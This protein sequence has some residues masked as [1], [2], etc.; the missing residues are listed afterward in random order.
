MAQIT[1][2]K[3]PGFYTGGITVNIT[4]P[5][6]VR[7]AIVTRGNVAPVFSE[8]IAYDKDG[9]GNKRPFLAVTQDGRG[10]VVYDGGFPKYYNTTQSGPV[11]TTFAQLN[12]SQKFFHNALKFC[13]NPAKVARGNN[14]VLIIGNTSNG[15]V[16]DAKNSIINNVGS[17]AQIRGTGMRDTWDPVFAIAGMV[18]TYMNLSDFPNGLADFNFPLLDQYAMVIALSSQA[19][20]NP[21]TKL[22]ASSPQELATYRAAGNGVF[23]IT[24]HCSDVYSS[25]ADAVARRGMFASDA[26][27]LAAPY[28]AY[29]SGNYD[30]TPVRVGDIRAENGDHPLF[31]NIGDNETIIGA[32]SESIVF[33][34]DHA[35]DQVDPTIVHSYNLSTA[36]TYWINPLAQMNDGSIQV[37]PY[38]YDIIDPSNLLLRDDR[39]RTLGTTYTTVKRAF[40]LEVFYNIPNPPTLSGYVTR[41][42][43]KHGTFT[44]IGNVLSTQYCSGNKGGFGF[45]P[46]DVVGFDVQ[47]P[48]LYKTTSTIAGVDRTALNAQWTQPSSLGKLL[49]AT[50]DYTG[51]KPTEALRAFWRYSNTQYRDLDSQPGN[52]F[53]IWPRVL[54]RCKRALSG[55]MAMCNLWVAPTQADWTANKPAN[56][57]ESET[58]VVVADGTVYTWW[59]TDGKGEWVTQVEKVGGFF[60]VGRTVSDKRGTG[61]YTIE[62]NRLVKQ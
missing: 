57:I 22:T 43:V 27:L 25:V 12:G 61:L 58:A 28:G 29:F 49:A 38:R 6:G 39:Q 46:T 10:N 51:L 16:F 56:P 33:V 15:Q 40:N 1:T 35:A 53:G 31:A 2:D 14:K 18:A 20:V 30:R 5:P 52:V 36:G 3:E 59:V 23:I 4:F 42:G 50:P 32:E 54:V 8:I 19:L 60:G 45:L 48:F 26:I 13:A 21:D 24:D 55:P 44:L 47:L 34:D 17:T 62:A 7:K 41:N 9:S 11:P 37:R